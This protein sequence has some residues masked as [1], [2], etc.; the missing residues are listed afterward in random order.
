MI[1]AHPH[2]T[3][4]PEDSVALLIVAIILASLAIYAVVKMRG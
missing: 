1:L 3:P 4:V 2:A